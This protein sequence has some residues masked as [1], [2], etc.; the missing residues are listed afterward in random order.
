M[1]IHLT[2]ANLGLQDIFQEA[3]LPTLSV[4]RF[5]QSSH[6]AQEVW[7]EGGHPSHCAEHF[8]RMSAPQ[9]K[10]TLCLCLCL[11]VS[12]ATHDGVISL[13]SSHPKWAEG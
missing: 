11:W 3:L 6:A 2:E 9:D 13:C 5:A 4:S 10:M 8:N 12:E 1:A 7:W